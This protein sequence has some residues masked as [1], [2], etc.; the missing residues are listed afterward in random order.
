M[1]THTS[2]L[3]HILHTRKRTHIFHG[4][5]HIASSCNIVDLVS[6]FTLA[7][8]M[9]FAKMLLHILR[10]LILFHSLLLSLSFLYSPLKIHYTFY[11]LLIFWEYIWCL[12]VV[13]VFSSMLEKLFNNLFYC[14]STSSRCLKAACY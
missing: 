6:A 1:S 10:Y 13:V 14:A 7:S 9:K 12:F 2:R 5:G 8:C 3:N 4:T 11:Y